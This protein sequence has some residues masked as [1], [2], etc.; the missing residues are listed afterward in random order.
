LS[1]PSLLNLICDIQ[2]ETVTYSDTGSPSTAWADK[3]TNEKCGIQPASGGLVSAEY[4]ERYNITNVGFF[5][6]SAD[7]V[8]GNKVIVGGTEYIVKR[9]FDAAGRGHHKEVGLELKA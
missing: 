5:L 2:E 9:V 4:A 1:Y 8:A 7:I 3:A 6:I